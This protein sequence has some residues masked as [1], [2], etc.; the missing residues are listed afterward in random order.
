MDGASWRLG[1]MGPLGDG[2]GIFIIYLMNVDRKIVNN[3]VMNQ[4][5]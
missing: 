2:W 5:Q 3:I 4:T 1:S